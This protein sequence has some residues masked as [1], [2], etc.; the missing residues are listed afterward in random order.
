V[1]VHTWSVFTNPVTYCK[2]RLEILVTFI[3]FHIDVWLNNKSWL[4]T[5]LIKVNLPIYQYNNVTK[6][7]KST[8]SLQINF[9]ILY[10]SLCEYDKRLLLTPL[11]QVKRQKVGHIHYTDVSIH[12]SWNICIH[13]WLHKHAHKHITHTHTH[14]HTHCMH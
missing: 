10:I 1:L 13:S 11:L 8:I 9:N 7:P 5:W 4:N 12:S 2:F 14:T 3:K 6:S